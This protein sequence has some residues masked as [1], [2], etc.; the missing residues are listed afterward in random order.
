MV[1]DTLVSDVLPAY[2]LARQ[3]AN[4]DALCLQL[5]VPGD[6]PCASAEKPKLI[7]APAAKPTNAERDALMAQQ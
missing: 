6:A 1:A 4:A 3:T 2:A 7:A 5:R